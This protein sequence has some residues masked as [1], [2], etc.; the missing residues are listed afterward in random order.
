MIYILVFFYKYFLI[1]LVKSLSLPFLFTNLLKLCL[2]NFN[3]AF[4]IRI[5]ELF[6]SLL[7]S[8]HNYDLSFYQ[9]LINGC[10]DLWNDLECCK[11]LSFSSPI[12][13]Q[14]F[15]DLYIKLDKDLPQL[16]FIKSIENLNNLQS[17][18]FKLL[19]YSSQIDCFKGEVIL[20]IAINAVNN[21]LNLNQL[22]D[23]IIG[24]F[25]ITQLI[26]ISNCTSNIN[27]FNILIRNFFSKYIGTL[28]SLD[29]MISV[30]LLHYFNKIELHDS[31]N[32]IEF[33]LIASPGA[34]YNFKLYLFILR[35]M[36]C[37]SLLKVSLC[38]LLIIFYRQFKQ[39]NFYAY[40]LV[41]LLLKPFSHSK[42]IVK[43]FDFITWDEES[44]PPPKSFKSNS[45]KEKFGNI[46]NRDSV[47]SL[48]VCYYVFQ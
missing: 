24:L 19:T 5:T 36:T 29:D 37:S 28:E 47:L 40:N 45:G 3:N 30:F 8:I 11:K 15:H 23:A 10:I 9:D 12:K 26:Q 4:L 38:N 18:L 20:S 48:F 22:N 31:L 33:I 21:Y 1:I 44:T 42:L 43:L 7:S 6:I 14:A 46:Y 35:K 25:C 17:C 16:Y 32:L 2:C 39:L 27:E 13:I 34:L 41:E